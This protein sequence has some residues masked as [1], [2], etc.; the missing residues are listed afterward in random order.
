MIFEDNDD[1][2]VQRI[3]IAFGKDIR[4]SFGRDSELSAY[5]NYAGGDEGPE[6]WYGYEPW[7][8]EKLK[9]LKRKWDPHQKFSYFAP[10]P[11]H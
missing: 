5:V 7:R 6:A 2:E 8:M 9:S 3:A 10:I 1:A 11:L 4:D